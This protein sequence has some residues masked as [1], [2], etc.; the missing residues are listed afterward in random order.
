MKRLSTA[1]LLGLGAGLPV[2]ER[3]LIRELAKLRLMTHAQL[4][5]LLDDGLTD[6]SP[7]TAARS[8]RRLLARLTDLGV[9]ARLDRR[10]G[11]LRRGSAGYIYYL[12]PV[13]QRLVAYWEGRGLTRGRFRPE[14]GGRHVRHRLAVSELYVQLRQADRDGVL[15]LLAF[16]AEPACWRRLTG[17]LGGQTTLKPDAFVR[18]GVGAYEDRYFIEVDLASESRSVIAHKVRV[19]ID[20]WR[21]GSEQQAHGVFPRVLLLTTTAARQAV[22]TDVCT[23]LPAETWTLFTITTLDRALDVLTGP[24]S[25]QAEPENTGRQL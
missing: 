1:A 15:D 12:G 7:I 21:S 23:E 9:F 22:L 13:G 10:I 24:V 4:S 6:S 17:S 20:Y 19:Y 2:R 11:G 25:S 16:D 5:V 8:A 18:V 3:E 14:P